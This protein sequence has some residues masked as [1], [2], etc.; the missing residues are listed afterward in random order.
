MKVYYNPE[1]EDLPFPE[2]MSYKLLVEKPS[3]LKDINETEG[4]KLTGIEAG[5]DIT[6]T[7]QA[8]SIVDQGDLAT[9]DQV[10]TAQIVNAAIKEAQLA[11]LA[12][13]EGK[14]R[15]AAVALAKLADEAVN[16]DKIWKGGNVITLSAQI[17][18]AIIL[19]AHVD[20][21]AAQKI[22]SQIVDA[23]IANIGWAK[24]LNVAIVDADI[25]NLT[26]EKL[27]GTYLTGKTVRTATSGERVQLDATYHQIEFYD[28]AGALQGIL[29]MSTE[30]LRVV[31]NIAAKSLMF[32]A[33][34]AGGSLQTVATFKTLECRFY[35]DVLPDANNQ[36]DLG[37]LSYRWKNLFIAGDLLISGSISG[38]LKPAVDNSDFI[39]TSTYGWKSLYFTDTYDPKI[40]R[41]ASIELEFEAANVKCHRNLVTNVTTLNLGSAGEYWNEVHYQSLH[42]HTPKIIAD[43]IG[44]EIL[45]S[46]KTK[47]GRLD[48][49][50]V[51][52][53]IK[54]NG[55]LEL[56]HLVMAN[57][58][59]TK[60][61]GK[62]VKELESTLVVK[63]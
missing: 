15:D 29:D 19:N 58:A 36:R 11:D 33:R 28:T 16:A 53:R 2:L 9:L 46:L 45:N 1:M 27:I 10:N 5:A 44:F 48:A 59:A 41:G 32:F 56:T 23:Q 54:V 57:I 17:K 60:D 39:G 49:V 62:K 13:S 24:I 14:L 26:V 37:S 31:S 42:P 35:K 21:L 30:G 8:A 4:V 63:N 12:V 38:P 40:Y 34:T 51:D 7:H 61:L 20:S 3:E 52:K 6:A 47:N 18:D 50:N 25:V 22:T 55:R 43:K